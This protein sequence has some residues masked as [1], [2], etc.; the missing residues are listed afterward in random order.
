[1]NRYR[2]EMHYNRNISRKSEKS[3]KSKNMHYNKN[4]NK[5]K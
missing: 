2:Y 1:M 3:K 5:V 4:I